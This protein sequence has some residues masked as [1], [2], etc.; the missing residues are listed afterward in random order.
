MQQQLKS[1][2]H[3]PVTTATATTATVGIAATT[4]TATTATTNTATD[5]LPHHSVKFQIMQEDVPESTTAATKV[6][7]HSRVPLVEKTNGLYSTTGIT[8]DLKKSSLRT[9]TSAAS[10][11]PP[12]VPMK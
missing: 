2:L 9:T 4:T 3:R 1:K 8:E 6:H 5:S 12:P 11:V 10:E 7:H